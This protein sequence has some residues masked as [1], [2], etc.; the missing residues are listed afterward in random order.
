MLHGTADLPEGS[1]DIPEDVLQSLNA[2]Q[3]AQLARLQDE[4]A[5]AR[6]EILAGAPR[7]T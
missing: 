2:E 5:R 4:A 6:E 1:G 7:E 3:K